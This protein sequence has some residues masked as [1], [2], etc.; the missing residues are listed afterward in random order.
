M[1]TNLAF[2]QLIFVCLLE[3]AWIGNQKYQSYKY[4]ML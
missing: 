1:I 4:N 3:M 2:I